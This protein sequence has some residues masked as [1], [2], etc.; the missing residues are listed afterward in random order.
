MCLPPMKSGQ[1]H[2]LGSA[3]SFP[4]NNTA[5]QSGSLRE[6]LRAR[7]YDAHETIDANMR[8]FGWGDAASYVRFLQIQHAARAP[9]E[10]WAQA[11]APA[12]AHGTAAPPAQSHLIAD[13]LRAMGHGVIGAPRPF[14]MPAG[15][16]PIGLY[17]AIAGSSLGNRAIAL[18]MKR[19][20]LGDLPQGFLSDGAMIGYW[21][22]LRDQLREG[23]NRG[24]ADAAVA[25]ALAVFEHFISV[26]GELRVREAA[27]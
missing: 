5:V 19:S 12:D 18:D 6:V 8:Q 21:Q 26:V 15:A 4:I 3:G 10:R 9:V 11:H 2:V 24:R 13:D 22:G 17:W 23:E 14:A 25:A 27:A 20:G 7:T 16:D 1:I